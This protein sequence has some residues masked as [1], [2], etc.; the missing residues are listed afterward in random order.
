MFVC[1]LYHGLSAVF[2]L[3]SSN[4][5][6]RRT[7]LLCHRLSTFLPALK[8]RILVCL[9]MH[10]HL[11]MCMHVF[12]KLWQYLHR[13][14]LLRAQHDYTALMWAADKGHM[15]CARLLL[16]AG[17]N[18]DLKDEVRAGVVLLRHCRYFFPA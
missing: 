2:L 1:T 7:V 15:E 11:Y 13:C 8:L 14:H 10:D 9:F 18:K 3:V 6:S 5:S 17:A 12:V 16:D 4:I